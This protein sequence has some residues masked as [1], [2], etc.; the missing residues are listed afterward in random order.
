M[1]AAMGE[2]EDAAPAKIRSVIQWCL[3]RGAVACI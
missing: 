2:A 1:S 3:G